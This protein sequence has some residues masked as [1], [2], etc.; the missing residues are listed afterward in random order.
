[1]IIRD[2][3]GN[4]VAGVGHFLPQAIDA[5]GA[6]L[7]ACRRAVMLA[8]EMHVEKIVLETDCREA[9]LKLLREDVDR[10]VH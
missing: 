5:E 8:K 1:M 7:F 2:H 4:F 10:S 9:G 3:H 6:E